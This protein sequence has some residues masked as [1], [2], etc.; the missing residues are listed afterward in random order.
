MPSSTTSSDS[1]RV[2]LVDDNDAM[3]ARAAAAL[4]ACCDIVGRAK[5]GRAALEAATTLTP[6]VIVLDISIPTMSGFEVAQRLRETGSTAAIV[7]LTVHD[8][9]DFV[10]AAKAVGGIGY[11]VKPRLASDLVVAV[12]EA[13]AGRP[14]VSRLA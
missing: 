8:G 5:D 12:R 6:D 14:F 1:V 9:E 2:L 11:V 10:V 13:H 7:F 3:L 4:A